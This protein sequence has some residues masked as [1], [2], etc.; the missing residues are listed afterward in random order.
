MEAVNE[1]VSLTYIIKTVLKW[2]ISRKLAKLI[3]IF[4]LLK[5]FLLHFFPIKQDFDIY[6][7]LNNVNNIFKENFPFFKK[8]FF[9]GSFSQNT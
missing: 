8:S 2:I 1:S 4:I 5:Y 6:Q 7:G 9:R 3:M